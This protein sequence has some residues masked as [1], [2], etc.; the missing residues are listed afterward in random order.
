[1]KTNLLLITCRI[2]VVKEIEEFKAEFSN[3]FKKLKSMLE[4]FT[5]QFPHTNNPANIYTLL[6]NKDL[7]NNAEKSS[8][9]ETNSQRQEQLERMVQA[10][11]NRLEKSRIIIDVKDKT[12]AKYE[13]YIRQFK[14]NDETIVNNNNDTKSPNP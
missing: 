13:K 14:S 9:F 2:R 8:N 6:A 4:D 5:K 3:K 1:M 11:L 12:I 10:L 7:N